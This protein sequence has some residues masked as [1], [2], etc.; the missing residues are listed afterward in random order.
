MRKVNELQPEDAVALLDAALRGNDPDDAR[1]EEE[2]EAAE[3][4]ALACACLPLALQITAGLLA[5]DPGLPLSEHAATLSAQGSVLDGLDD[6]DRN[7]RATFN[8][9]L[10]R[11]TPQTQN[12]FRLLSLNPGPDISTAAAAV[13]ADQPQPATEQLLKQL[14][15]SHLIE[16]S[17]ASAG[18]QRDGGVPGPVGRAVCR[19]RR[20]DRSLERALAGGG[21]TGRVPRPGRRRHQ[22][23]RRVARSGGRW[24]RGVGP[25]IGGL[26]LLPPGR[27]VPSGPRGFTEPG[28]AGPAS[29]ADARGGAG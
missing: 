2:P 6:G 25:G 13:L 29:G 1:V 21:R 7:L 26:F 23:S 15:A 28:R 18:E 22:P 3:R 5:Q 17:S 8:Q 16:R 27:S 24:L 11:H 9:S 14:A 10:D 19:G 12:L 4:V 20:P